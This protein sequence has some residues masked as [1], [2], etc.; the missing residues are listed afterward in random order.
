MKVYFPIFNYTSAR[1]RFHVSSIIL[2]PFRMA[3]KAS[4]ISPSVAT[5][6]GAS[7]PDGRVLSGGLGAAALPPPP[8]SFGA[9]SPSSFV[10]LTLNAAQRPKTKTWKTIAAK[11]R[12]IASQPLGST[13][14]LWTGSSVKNCTQHRGRGKARQA[15]GAASGGAGYQVAVQGR[16]VD[17]PQ[18]RIQRDE[19][20]VLE[21]LGADEHPHAHKHHR[22]V[23]HQ[24]KLR[25]GRQ[26][27]PLGEPVE[28]E[29]PLHR[30][31]VR[32][33]HLLVQLL[34]L[35]LLLPLITSVL[36]EHQRDE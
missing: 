12:L 22:R 36:N 17:G 6:A 18:H 32:L 35:Q 11:C 8:S 19:S 13:R 25:D 15:R 34:R 16:S 27:P 31:L 33:R 7:S 26:H 4:S 3:A 14:P 5:A 1:A 29:L 24:H 30:L 23:E 9:A 20:Q 10:E 2:L 28:L 21:A